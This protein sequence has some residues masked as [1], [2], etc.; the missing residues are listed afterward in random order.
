MV[1]FSCV[2]CGRE[3]RVEDAN[4]G[5]SF[6]C[7]ECGPKADGAGASCGESG[8]VAEGSDFCPSVSECPRAA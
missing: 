7:R 6:A 8:A 2:D 5:R 3:Y 1:T 4:A